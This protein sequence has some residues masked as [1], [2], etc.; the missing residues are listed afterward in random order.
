MRFPKLPYLPVLL[1][2]SILWIIG[3]A[4][5]VTVCSAN[6]GEMPVAVPQSTFFEE[7]GDSLH[8]GDLMDTKHVV[9]TPKHHLK[10]LADWITIP[11]IG[12]ASIGD[13]FLLA[14]D[15]LQPY[16]LGAWLALLWKKHEE[17]V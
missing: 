5:N 3:A 17:E 12:T 7:G 4:L 1:F 11:G 6:H 14:G 2:P 15:T 16:C 9:M 8:G 13:G 10:F